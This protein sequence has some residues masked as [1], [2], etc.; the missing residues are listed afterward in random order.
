MKPDG[1][2]TGCERVK[3][4]D[5]EGLAHV[6]G[7]LVDGPPIHAGALFGRSCGP[8][9]DVRAEDEGDHTESEVLVHAGQPLRLY[10]EAGLFLDLASYACRNRLVKLQ[11]AARDLPLARIPTLY[12][13]HLSRSVG[14]DRGNAH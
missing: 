9:H 4:A 5:G 8:R 7:D 12:D 3:D 1:Y 6:L 13:Q 14:H 10:D 11:D 2:A